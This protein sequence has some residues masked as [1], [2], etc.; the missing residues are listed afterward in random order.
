VDLTV[1]AELKF[2][3]NNV[4]HLA[5]RVL[6]TKQ[7]DASFLVQLTCF[8]DVFFDW[9]CQVD[10]HVFRELELVSPFNEF[11]R[12]LASVLVNCLRD[13][14]SY[15]AMLVERDEMSMSFHVVNKIG[16]YRIVELLELSFT[17]GAMNDHDERVRVQAR[18]DELAARCDKAKAALDELSSMSSPVAMVVGGLANKKQLG[19]AAASRRSGSGRG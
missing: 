6:C 17:P 14:S 8:T 9:V 7:H 3:D 12:V 2:K 10:E 1:P 19:S 18:F 11:S 5:L 4:H 16:D 13:P 15:A